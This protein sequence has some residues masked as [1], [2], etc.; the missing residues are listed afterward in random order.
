MPGGVAQVTKA[1]KKYVQ[2]NP[3][4]QALYSQYLP[5]NIRGVLT[6]STDGTGRCEYKQ[7]SQWTSFREIGLSQPFEKE[8][9]CDL[10]PLGPYQALEAQFPPP[11]PRQPGSS[12]SSTQKT[13][14]KAANTAR[15]GVLDSD[16]TRV[17]LGRTGGLYYQDT[18]FQT[19][20]DPENEEYPI[21]PT[22]S[23]AVWG[24]WANVDHII[25]RIDVHGCKCGTNS[26]ANAAIISA[27][28]NVGMGNNMTDTRR[29]RILC[30][31][32]SLKFD[33]TAC[34]VDA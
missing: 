24:Q 21:P 30:E 28:L 13:K 34:P 12:F 7:G 27:S 2:Y 26:Y 9:E 22:I 1:C 3:T 11:S 14:L 6:N 8:P 15:W 5:D 23:S 20:D 17:I 31:W 18:F 33:T 29:R 16:Y 32:T 19:E 4:G 25:P 10:T